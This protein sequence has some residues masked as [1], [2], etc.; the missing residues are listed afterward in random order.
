MVEEE[1]YP[2]MGEFEFRH[3]MCKRSN[4]PVLPKSTQI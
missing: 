4:Q 2:L 3:Y 1:N